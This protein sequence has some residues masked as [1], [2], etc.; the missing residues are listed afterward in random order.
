MTDYLSSMAS[1]ARP[2]L[3]VEPSLNIC[4]SWNKLGT[5]VAS[6]AEKT[7]QSPILG[8]RVE[9][10]NKVV[11]GA[12]ELR[13]PE[14]PTQANLPDSDSDGNEVEGGV[15]QSSVTLLASPKNLQ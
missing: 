3:T 7:Q 12:G 10:P 6:T 4:S 8:Q 1:L 14:R 13:G 9:R 15:A 11:K 2:V 5:T